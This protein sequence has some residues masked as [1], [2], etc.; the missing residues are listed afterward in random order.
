MKV[1][2]VCTHAALL[3][4]ILLLFASTSYSD[5]F[6]VQR[7]TRPVNAFLMNS[8][9]SDYAALEKL[10]PVLRDGGADTVIIGPLQ[11]T[12][13]PDMELLPNLVYLAHQAGLKI[14]FILPVRN[15]PR[16]LTEHPEWSDM[17]YD[18]G[19]GTLQPADRINLFDPAAGEFLVKTFRDIASYSIDGIL[20]GLDFFYG[21]TEGMTQPV[22]DEYKRRY[23]AALVMGRAIS[24]VG[25]GD[26]GPVVMEYGEGYRQ[27]AEMKRDRLKELLEKTVS[28]CRAVNPDIVFGVPLFADG[29]SSSVDMLDRYGHDVKAFSDSGVEV[30]WMPLLHRDIRAEQGLGYKQV[31]EYISRAALAAAAVVKPPS[32]TVIALQTSVQGKVLPFSEIEEAAAIVKKSEWT[33]IALTI[34][35]DTLLPVLLTKK[36]FRR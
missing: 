25:G 23:G 9:P 33:N 5:E 18:L 6:S 24:R 28:A 22:L 31:M 3:A 17:R 7:G 2:K 21:D 30:F 8:I 29:L 35:P 16:V 19:S 27:W 26:K 10:M 15:I 13:L 11:P 36:I 12:D 4:C 20:F 1:H 32:K 14:F 34:G